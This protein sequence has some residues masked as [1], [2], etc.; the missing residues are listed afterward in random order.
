M[1]RSIQT[2]RRRLIR[3]MLLTSA[4]GIGL[5]CAALILLQFS[6]SRSQALEQGATL[7]RIIATNSTAALAF[8]DRGD[9]EQVLASLHTEPSIVDAVLY[10]AHGK[11]FAR[12]PRDGRSDRFPAVP[13]AASHTFRG[14]YL[15][16]FLTVRERPDQDLGFLYLRSDL[17]SSYEKLWLYVAIAAAI[18]AGSL[19]VTYFLA[20]LLQQRISRP[21]RGIIGTASAVS[22]HGDFAVRAPAAEEGEFRLLT[23]AFN[24]ML[25]RIETQRSALLESEA[26]LRAALD[27]SLSAVIVMDAAG[28]ILDWNPQAERI[29]GWSRTEA[30]GRELAD[31]IIPERSRGAHRHG[32]E[33]FLATGHGPLLNRT[34]EVTAIRRNGDEFPAETAITVLHGQGPLSFCGFI[35]D[36]TERKQARSRLQTQLA[37]LDLLQRTTHAIG[38]RQDLQSIFQVILRNLEDNMPVEFTCVCLYDAAT[39]TLAVNSVGSLSSALAQQAGIVVGRTLPVDRNG[40]QR[41]LEGVLVYEPDIADVANGLL[42]QLAQAGLRSLVAAPMI[43][44][45]KV[46][47]V[48]LIGRPQADAFSSA[49]CEFL[50][51]LSEHVALAA[52]QIR[53]YTDLQQA[54]DDLRL[55]QHTIMQQ[56]RLRALGQ[57]ASGVAHDINNAIS[58]IALYTESLLERE[59]NLSDRTREY[60]RIIQRAITDV[61]QT[62]ARMREFYRQR[63]QQIELLPVEINVL[64][65]Q[66]LT[67][68][69]ARWND[70]PQERG[71]VIDV[72]T[73]LDA[74]LPKVLG[75]ESDLRDALTNLIFN[76]V[77]AMPA[78]G[79]LTVRTRPAN[80]EGMTPSV[81]LEVTDTGVGMD[82]NTRRR[83]L[84]PFFTT[85][86]ERGS[87]MGLAMV[88]G[89]AERHKAQLEIDS[90]PGAGT[91]MRLRFAAVANAAVA[92]T[93]SPRA[94]TPTRRLRL[95][96]IDDDPLL[97]EALLR[98]LDDE[99]HEVTGAQG[100]REGINTFLQA[101]TTQHPFDVVMTDLGMPYVDGR[102][103]AA[104]IK[105]ASPQTPV[106]LLTGWGQRLN[107]EQSIPEHVDVLL[108]KPP[109][110]AELRQVL[111]EL[112]TARAVT[113]NN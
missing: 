38:E 14:K 99:G 62:V 17:S 40:L 43:V 89:M 90:A 37:R 93:Y 25:D 41:C 69:R 100:G 16:Q 107:T 74:D 79:T 55:S 105:H 110:I 45:K 91:T 36:V 29:F 22:D 95:L 19:L 70:M 49:D 52:H 111:A 76:A 63:D 21:L 15:E 59:P 56:E 33:Q 4:A 27:S 13:Q 20:H 5:T 92:D 7:A 101:Q 1:L 44:E 23:A 112:T 60:L 78:G 94:L 81:E 109:R 30:I 103:V 32:L 65:Q 88:Y 82:E 50:R 35:T 18:M 10:D 57:M 11:I 12:Y 64:V 9:A 87:G 113:L 2:I 34:I 26:R 98:I 24:K 106:V 68:T 77:D 47:G 108:G 39:Q 54:Y 31:T 48:L 86:G 97:S 84:E 28:L 83:C 6:N 67:L 46:F 72:R 85:K 102:A 3:L 104:A 75:T 58:P 73:D 80:R 8:G 51:Q 42:Q 53:L 96:V 61:G 71:I 66:A